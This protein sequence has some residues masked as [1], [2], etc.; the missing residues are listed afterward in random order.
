MSTVEMYKTQQLN[1]KRKFEYLRKT[2]LKKSLPV[3][4]SWAGELNESAR[5]FSKYIDEVINTEK[6]D[7]KRRLLRDKDGNHNVRIT[8]KKE[9]MGMVQDNIVLHPYS[10]KN[11]WT[12]AS[13]ANPMSPVVSN[14]TYNFQSQR[15][16]G[17][18]S[19]IGSPSNQT[20]VVTGGSISTNSNNNNNNNSVLGPVANGGARDGLIQATYDPM[21][22]ARSADTSL[23][24]QQI[25]HTMCLAAG[26]NDTTQ[27]AAYLHGIFNNR[28]T[29]KRI[30]SYKRHLQDQDRIDPEKP[31]NDPYEQL[32][33]TLNTAIK[34]KQQ[35]QS[36]RKAPR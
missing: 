1:N 27:I 2:C 18:S 3:Q 5:L 14:G 35:Q 10:L 23:G 11:E 6:D 17:P 16:S 9:E 28:R 26:S 8:L 7:Q 25:R 24:M 22:F 36:R 31:Y 30:S 21:A 33:Q 32:L 12:P 34:K 4:E 15:S 20:T 19:D 13:S 29:S